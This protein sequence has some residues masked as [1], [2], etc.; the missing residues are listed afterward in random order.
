M[1]KRSSTATKGDLMTAARFC[2]GSLF[3]ISTSLCSSG[4]KRTDV[5]PV[6]ILE[7]APLRS[8]VRAG[9][10]ID[11][12]AKVENPEGSPLT[13]K[14]TAAK[15]KVVVPN[16]AIPLATY[17]APAESGTDMIKVEAMS[18]QRTVSAK[19]ASVEVI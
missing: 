19:T 12:S 17:S 18:G 13:Y 7:V 14:W 15:G 10:Q 8:E 11:F 1:R 16:S 4:C 6:R 2:L 9:G 3:V 5:G